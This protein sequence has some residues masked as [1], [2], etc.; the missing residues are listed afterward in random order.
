MIQIKFKTVSNVKWL[1]FGSRE[2]DYKDLVFDAYHIISDHIMARGI[3]ITSKYCK[4]IDTLARDYAEINHP[5]TQLQPF[6]A[7]WNIYGNSAGAVRNKQMVKACD[8]GLAIWNGHSAGTL[9]TIRFL[10][11][12]HKPL[13]VYW[14]HKGKKSKLNNKTIGK[15]KWIE[16]ISLLKTL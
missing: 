4:G 8:I 2:F 16:N 13:H 14:L 6:E 7:L 3:I 11:E 9:M 15:L 5:L 12:A 10:M 1:V